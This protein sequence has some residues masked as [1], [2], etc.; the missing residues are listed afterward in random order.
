MDLYLSY[1][2]TYRQMEQFKEIYGFSGSSF[3]LVKSPPKPKEN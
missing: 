2:E 1:E 3:E